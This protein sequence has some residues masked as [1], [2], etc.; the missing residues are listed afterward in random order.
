MIDP[1]TQEMPQKRKQL[2]KELFHQALD[3]PTE[4]RAA[5]LD[6]ACR[7]REDVREEVDALL[8]AHEEAEKF[9]AEPLERGLATE[10]WPGP[11]WSVLLPPSL[12]TAS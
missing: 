2:L 9:L 7:E 10:R 4:A 5:F 6:E 12:P 3:Q 11:R 1:E 8:L